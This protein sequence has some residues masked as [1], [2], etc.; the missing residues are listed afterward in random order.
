MKCWYFRFCNIHKLCRLF[1][2]IIIIARVKPWGAAILNGGDRSRTSIPQEVCCTFPPCQQWSPEQTQLLKI[3]KRGSGPLAQVLQW[4]R[5]QMDDEYLNSSQVTTHYVDDEV[6]FV[7]MFEKAYLWNYRSDYKII[8]LVVSH[9]TI[10]GISTPSGLHFIT[11]KVYGRTTL[12]TKSR[13]QS[14]LLVNRCH[15]L[16]CLLTTSCS[17]M[18]KCVFLLFFRWATN[19]TTIGSNWRNR[20]ASVSG[21]T[22]GVSARCLHKA[23]FRVA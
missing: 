10:S 1:I 8:S 20:S 16:K 5:W 7:C 18:S 19:Q 17:C 15:L 9:T 2:I 14:N 6:K 12:G 11:G 21:W 23:S 13:A 4:C 3:P 22:K